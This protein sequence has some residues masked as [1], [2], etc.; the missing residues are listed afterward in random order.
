MALFSSV[1]RGAAAVVGFVALA[2]ASP[3]LAEYPEKPIYVVTNAAAGG[4]TDAIVRFFARKLTEELGKETIVENRNGAQGNIGIEYV[5]RAKPDG[6]T[7]L[8]SPSSGTSAAPYIFK[9]LNYDPI[10]DFQVVA[11]LIEV[12]TVLSVDPNLP[13][14]SIQELTEYIKTKGNKTYGTTTHS[15]TAASEMY[16]KAAGLNLQ[17]VEYKN[18]ANILGDLATGGIDFAFLGATYPVEQA[19]AGRL[20][21]LGVAN[22]KRSAVLPDLPTM[23]EAGYPMVS[24]S[25]WFAAQVPAKTPTPVVDKLEAAF[26]KILAQPDTR[27]YLANTLAADVIAG[28]RAEAS[29]RMKEDV[30]AWAEYA[31]LA[32]IVPQ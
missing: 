30:K 20:K 28:R 25:G 15:L 9:K 4:G 1:L 19:R 8:I 29:A 5:A 21:L 24:V 7:I 6:Y 32:G 22:P 12:A 14:N 3:A 10:K 23:I 27:E 11:S 17:K 31:K 18:V 13:V 26:L 16:S 2:S